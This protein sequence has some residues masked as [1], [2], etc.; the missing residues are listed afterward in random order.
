MDGAG[1]VLVVQL[2]P[3][4]PD[5]AVQVETATLLVLTGLQVV[6]VQLLPELALDP[7]QLETPVGPVVIGAGHVVVVQ[8]LPEV[9]PWKEHEDTGVLFTTS[10]GQVVLVQLLPAAAAAAVQ[11]EIAAGPVVT[12]VGQVVVV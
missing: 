11:L 4:F 9:G 10:V 5:D 7:V 6:V 2:L 8:L 1:Q 12:G 3:V